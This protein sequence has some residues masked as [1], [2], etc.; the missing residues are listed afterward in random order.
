MEHKIGAAEDRG[1]HSLGRFLGRLCVRCF[2]RGKRAAG[3]ERQVQTTC[4]L[5]RT[6]QQQRAF[7]RTEGGRAGLHRDRANKGP[8]NHRY[9]RADELGQSNARHRFGE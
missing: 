8:K 1:E 5:C 7:R 2:R 4:Q 3:A 6:V 9:A